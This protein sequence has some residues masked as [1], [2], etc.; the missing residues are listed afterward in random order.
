MKCPML[1]R[2]IGYLEFSEKTA[3]RL[4]A[5]CANP[6]QLGI[7]KHLVRVHETHKSHL[8]IVSRDGQESRKFRKSFAVWRWTSSQEIVLRDTTGMALGGIKSRSFIGIGQG[9]HKPLGD[10]GK[11]HK[12]ELQKS[13]KSSAMLAEPIK[14]SAMLAEPSKNSAR[15]AK[16]SFTG[17]P[18]ASCYTSLCRGLKYAKSWHVTAE[19]QY[20]HGTTFTTARS[21]LGAHVSFICKKHQRGINSYST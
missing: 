13:S 16:H 7:A 1:S 12:T 6:W 9:I 10:A 15:Q 18:R 2:E 19:W 21:V 8:V 4:Q 17:R 5:V 11:S 20:Q 14:N 3:L